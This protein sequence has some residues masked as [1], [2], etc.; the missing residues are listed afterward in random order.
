MH[1]SEAI[2][3]RNTSWVLH[4]CVFLFVNFVLVALDQWLKWWSSTNLPLGGPRVLVDGVLGLRYFH[5]TGAAFGFLGGQDWGRWVL[6]VLVT[7]LLVLLAWYYFWLPAGGK[8]WRIRVPLA[9]V[10]AGGLGNLIDRVRL[11]YVVDMLE[12]LFVR[13]AI[14]NLA[15]V[16]V[17]AGMAMLIAGT[18]SMGA[19]APWPF[20]EKRKN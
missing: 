11:G 15:D 10:F 19:D 8:L 20:G 2:E 7:L 4:G 6:T 13:F 5:N 9:F 16:F 1:N 3:K 18:F 12:F 17:V 14:F